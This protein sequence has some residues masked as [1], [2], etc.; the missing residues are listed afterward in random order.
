MKV[1]GPHSPDGNLFNVDQ[2]LYELI[3]GLW[4]GDTPLQD[5]C[6]AMRCAVGRLNGRSARRAL[7]PCSHRNNSIIGILRRD[8]HLDLEV[9]DVIVH[10][11]C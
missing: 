3:E 9:M 10:P 1:R 7:A 6:V 2:S 8:R 11:R 5:I 4:R